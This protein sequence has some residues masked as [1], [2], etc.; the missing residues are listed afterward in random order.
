MEQ[1]NR[2][3]Q[4][5]NLDSVSGYCMPFRDEKEIEVLKHYGENPE[6]HEMH[7]GMTFRTHN[8]LLC[9]VA[10]GQVISIGNNAEQGT[11]LTI[12]YGK[13]EVLYGHLTQV[14]AQY[15]QQVSA[16]RKVGVAGDSLYLSVTMDGTEM[17]PQDFIRMLYGNVIAWSQDKEPNPEIGTIDYDIHTRYDAHKEQLEEWMTRFYANYFMA[18]ITRRY[19][20]SQHMYQSL[21]N[22]FRTAPDKGYYYEDI[23]T[24]LNPLG[25]GARAIPL[26]EK[27][28]NLLIGDFL[29][30][31][32]LKHE[33]YLPGT[34]EDVKKK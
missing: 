32:A 3:S 33:M 19:V 1:E 15:G 31:M 25:L 20:P 2:Y 16:G 17:D 30:Y 22:I 10:D 14:F 34:D 27:V 4:D 7:H 5:Y 8:N 21:L 9:A 26:I 28:Q 13:Y 11:H 23:P 18:V 6:T 29:N 24:G 12:R